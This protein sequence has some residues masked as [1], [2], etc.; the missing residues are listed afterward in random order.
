MKCQ[1]CSLE[2]LSYFGP[3][4]GAYILDSNPVSLA[5]YTAVNDTNLQNNDKSKDEGKNI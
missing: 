2:T 3:N 1:R 4:C 5:K